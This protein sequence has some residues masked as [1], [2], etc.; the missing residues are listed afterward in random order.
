MQTKPFPT[1]VQSQKQ[2]MERSTRTS[3]KVAVTQAE[4]VWLD[5]DATV[6]KTCLLISEAAKN[7]AELIAFPEC[8]IPGYPAWIW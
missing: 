2:A 7:G 3:V 8:W 4:P 1:A 6:E 5:L